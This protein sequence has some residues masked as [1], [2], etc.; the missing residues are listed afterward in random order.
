MNGPLLWFA[1]RGTGV[2]LV[3]LLTVSVALG[4]MSTA[5]VGSRWWPRFLTQGLHKNVA[6]LS[7]LLLAMHVTTAV[8][9]SYVDIR[10]S[11]AFVPGRS[12]YEPLWLALGTIALDLLLAVTLTSLLRRRMAHRS[13]R[14]VH[15]AS[16]S[17][18]A[19][20]LVH[21]LGMGTDAGEPWSV[22]VSV[23]CVAV[24]AAAGV[25]RLAIAR[26]EQVLA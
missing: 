4:V 25:A 11:D 12:A 6:L 8:A 26:H 23:S 3:G 1:N 24:V 16:Y 19:L 14:V 5:R 10:W 15:V 21:G 18:W 9:D 2:V 7:V 17:A 13:W 20:G 22:A